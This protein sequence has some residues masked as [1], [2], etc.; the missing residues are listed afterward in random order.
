MVIRRQHKNT[1]ASLVLFLASHFISAWCYAIDNPD[2]P[3][4]VANF[5]SRENV[6][7]QAVNNPHNSNRAMLQAYD[8]YQLF[9]DTELSKAY[10]TLKVNLAEK[11]QQELEIAR[12]NW[13]RFRDAEFTLINNNW[14]RSNFGSSAN[15]SRGAYRSSIIRARIIQLLHYAQNY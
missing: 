2:A 13:L 14:T 10:Q 7:R 12:K 11:Q 8:R 4:L 3:N 5:E 6:Y 9:L 15:L 1:G